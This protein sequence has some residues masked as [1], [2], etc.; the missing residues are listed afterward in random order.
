[1]QPTSLSRRRLIRS[2][3]AGA[4]AMA[5]ARFAPALL[6]AEPAEDEQVIP[7][8]DP[9]P[10]D[11]K[12]PAVKWQD[13]R[14]WITPDTDFFAVSHYGQQTVGAAT[15]RLKVDGTVEKPL[16]LTLEQVKDRPSRTITA[17]LECSGN[18]AS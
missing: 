2:G 9:Q 14:D 15:W 10:V 6:A 12:K 8:I 18:G 16:E 17:T 4:G 1:M 5:V 7:F 11:P 3:I 13:L